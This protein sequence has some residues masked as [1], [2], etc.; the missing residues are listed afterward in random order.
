MFLLV[1]SFD[2]STRYVTG[3][4]PFCIVSGKR[5]SFDVSPVINPGKFRQ[6]VTI[7]QNA[8]KKFIFGPFSAEDFNKDKAQVQVHLFDAQQALNVKKINIWRSGGKFEATMILTDES[9]PEPMESK[10]TKQYRE[11]DRINKKDWLGWIVP[12][13]VDAGAKGLGTILTVSTGLP[14]K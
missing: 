13:A 12:G 6:A 3:K 11:K 7:R 14:L 8:D 1:F 10:G 9:D 5:E 4:E 2:C